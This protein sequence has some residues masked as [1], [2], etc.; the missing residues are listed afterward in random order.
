MS[1][2]FSLSIYNESKETNIST[3][4]PNLG[5]LANDTEMTKAFK[6]FALSTLIAASV[7]GN[8]L[9][10][11][12]VYKNVNKRMR[13]VSNYL[14]VNLSI[15]DMLLAIFSL[16]RMIT[17]VHVGYE[18]L[19]DGSLGLFL[20]KAHHFFIIQL[21]FVSTMNFTAIAIDRFVAVFFPL[22]QILKGKLL[23]LIIGAT[24]FIPSIFF[25]FYWKMM[26]MEVRGS[27]TVCFANVLKIFP[28]EQNFY[29]FKIAESIIVTGVTLT[30]TVS[31]YFA[32]GAKLLLTRQPGHQ[33]ETNARNREAVARRV[34]RMM[35]SVVL[36]FCFCW[37]PQWIISII[38]KFV[39]PQRSICKNPNANFVKLVVA[40]S[41]SAITPFIY[42]VF[43]GN[44]RTSFK[45]IL[46]GVVC[47]KRGKVTPQCNSSR[48]KPY[49][50]QPGEE[51]ESHRPQVFL[52]QDRGSP[53]TD[54]R[55]LSQSSATLQKGKK[56]KQIFSASNV[57]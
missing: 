24:W 2:M 48:R 22:S 34:V 13:V 5:D 51:V 20:C 38:C 3:E 31:L 37:S 40:Y 11:A 57:E 42:P 12:S 33:Q 6:T 8:S 10:I 15:A 14:V 27:T 46:R 54:V 32:I 29:E 30:I 45:R 56:V 1:S 23:Y 35:A 21:L 17:L 7:F 52:L 26:E 19:V 28:T 41:N 50:A 25:A 4:K 36:V 44:F 39:D 55:E 43:S 53:K 18:W 47:W 9:V 16:S 49:E